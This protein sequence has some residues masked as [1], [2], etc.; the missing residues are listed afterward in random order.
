MERR[1]FSLEVLQVESSLKTTTT[2]SSNHSLCF[3]LYS[4]PQVCLTVEFVAVH[5][6]DGKRARILLAKRN[7]VSRPTSFFFVSLVIVVSAAGFYVVVGINN[8]ADDGA[9]AYLEECDHDSRNYCTAH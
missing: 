5:V 9:A 1:R 3:I 2:E 7:G 4:L 8:I 6:C